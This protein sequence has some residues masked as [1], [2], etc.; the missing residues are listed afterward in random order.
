MKRGF[1]RFVWGDCSQ[2]GLRN[3]KLKRDIEIALTN[4]SFEYCVYVLGKDNFSLLKNKGLNCIL[5]DEKDV[6]FNIE[7]QQYAHKLYLLKCAIE[8]YDEMIYLD[9]DCL[10]CNKINDGIWTVLNK[11][12][13]FQANLYLY[14]NK[15]CL[16]R[17]DNNEKRKVCNGGFLYFRNKKI[18]QKIVDNYN[19]LLREMLIFKEKRV[20][21]GKDLRFR[22]KCIIYDDEPSISKYVDDYLG[23]WKGDDVYF[24][25]FEP[26]ICNLR[27]CSCFSKEKLNIKNEI[28]FIHSSLKKEGDF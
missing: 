26:D 11:K 23:G 8:D 24:N 5:V 7:K 16:W 9:W 28:F 1:V 20:K 21:C 14:K 13:S 15:K 27:K 2:N 3:G 19:D 12:E 22:E 6:I 25:L 4:D 18:P 10:S 17:K